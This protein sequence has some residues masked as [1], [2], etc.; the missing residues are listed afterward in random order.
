MTTTFTKQMLVAVSLIGGTIAATGAPVMPE[1]L[2]KLQ[3]IEKTTK[4]K[5]APRQA[6]ESAEECAVFIQLPE[7]LQG[8]MPDICVACA[9]DQQLV[10]P[11]GDYLYLLPGTYDIVARFTHSN[12]LSFTFNDYQG[13]VVLENVEV[14]GDMTINVDPSTI[15]HHIEFQPILPDGNPMVLPVIN[16]DEDGNE[17]P[18]SDGS[19]PFSGLTIIDFVMGPG[20]GLDTSNTMSALI[21]A[22]TPWGFYDPTLRLGIHINEI[23]D[24]IHIGI[25]TELGTPE[26]DMAATLL[27]SAEQAGSEEGI[28]SNNPL[29][30]AV[31]DLT[32]AWTPDGADT[33]SLIEQYPDELGWVTPYGYAL[34]RMGS[35]INQ[36]TGGAIMT[37][38]RDINIY[39]FAASRNNIED[40]RAHFLVAPTKTELI[41]SGSEVIQTVNVGAWMQPFDEGEWIVYPDS[42][43]AMTAESPTA[44][45]QFCGVESFL[46]SVSNNDD[47]MFLTAPLLSTT[48]NRGFNMF[49]GTEYLGFNITSTGRMGEL[50]NSDMSLMKS[51]LFVN[52]V[53]VAN[54]MS[55]IEEW[56][57]NYESDMAGETE[58]KLTDS[59]FEVDGVRTATI[60]TSHFDM[61]NA[62]FFPPSVTMMQVRSNEGKLSSRI[63]GGVNNT[64]IISAGDFEAGN[65]MI[66]YY[67]QTATITSEPASF[68]LWYAPTGTEEWTELDCTKVTEKA[69]TGIGAIYEATVLDNADG[70]KDVKV[71]VEDATGNWQ[72]QII[73][74]AFHISKPTGIKTVN[75]NSEVTVN[76]NTIIA[77]A[78]AQIYTIDGVRTNGTDLT[79]G[80]YIVRVADRTYKISV[81]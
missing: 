16:I 4:F 5:S 15:T 78:D 21:N 43:L 81:K 56:W 52:G 17:I 55:A 54:S 10:N 18:V 20:W 42:E 58:L 1:H 53:K 12:P 30:Y 74:M 26:Y 8:W 3:R 9:P 63:E 40:P 33:N 45:F 59:N 66:N 39:K 35:D 73:S 2:A 67:G 68:N 57:N 62:D 25:A 70:W 60:S 50:R 41:K 13:Y 64:L 34:R 44:N 6:A 76:G 51:E 77:P 29:E 19:M 71:R 75:G 27:M 61:N 28:I 31:R 37:S 48:I 14:N 79:T 65:E 49:E 11:S 23:S 69:I 38:S 22:E 32:P 36:L 24:R 47:T 7:D 80:I 46:S 72:E